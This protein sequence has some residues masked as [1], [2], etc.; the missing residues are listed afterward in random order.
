[1]ARAAKLRCFR[2]GTNLHTYRTYGHLFGMTLVKSWNRAER[3]GQGM[4]LR[5]F[6]GRFYSLDEQI[7][8]KGDL[9]FLII[10]LTTVIG[11]GG[12]EFLLT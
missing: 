9:I 11:L 1:L 10:I 7:M 12:L 2:P 4:L 6:H 3:V 8:A 5:G